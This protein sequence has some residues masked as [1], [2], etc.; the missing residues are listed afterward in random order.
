MGSIIDG[1]RAAFGITNPEQINPQ[2]TANWNAPSRSMT[3]AGH[4]WQPIG[5]RRIPPHDTY[6]NV[7]P[8]VNAIAQRFSTLTPYAINPNGERITPA[9][10]AVRAIYAPN[11]T[12]SAREFL[13]N[14]ATNILTQSHLDI[15]IWTLQGSKVL[16]G[17]RI[18][19]ENI[20]GYTFLPASSR[21]YDT[22]RT[23]YWH[24]TELTINGETDTYQFS[25]DE[26]IALSY[27]VHPN[28]PTRGI[29]PTMTIHKWANVD[30]MIA[31]YERGFF[32]NGAVPAGM[33]GIISDTP[34]D[35]QQNKNKLEDTFRGAGK[36]NG[37]VYNWIPTDPVTRKPSAT[38]KLV[39][40]PFQQSN[41]TLDLQT[42]SDVVNNRMANALAVPD[43]VRGIDNG[44]TYANAQQAE[45][46]F[47]ENTLQPLALT[48]WDKW[49]FEL[50]RI[51]GGL[52]YAIT[53][54]LDLPAQTDVENVQA[55]T[56]KTKV[57]TLIELVN[58]G[59]EVK[60]AVKALGLPDEFASLTL[61]KQEQSTPTLTL[62]NLQTPTVENKR[63][64]D[65]CHVE[66]KYNYPDYSEQKAM[67]ALLPA[68]QMFMR[69]VIRYTQRSQNGLKDDLGVIAAQWADDVQDDLDDILIAYAKR[70]GQN[71]RK[72]F[73]AWAEQHPDSEIAQQITA[74]NA[75]EWA[76][77]YDWSELPDT[78][79]EAY[80]K[81][82]NNVAL[83]SAKNVRD[84]V[85]GILKKAE[86]EQ[87]TKTE[88]KDALTAQVVDAHAELLARNEI[89]ASQRLGD[90][91]SARNMSETVGLKLDKEWKTSDDSGVCPFCKSMEGT[92]IDLDASF[93]DKG[94]SVDIDGK[95]YANDYEDMVTANGHPNCRCYILHKVHGEK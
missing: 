78:V 63:E 68:T 70:T 28:D 14:I 69:R 79:S 91:Y 73:K 20:A 58:A 74:M 18:T 12:F 27:S 87:W 11:D 72:V 95:T 75:G 85:I 57:D 60:A 36:N 88:I 67:G 3:D 24:E 55:T 53:F 45:R 64:S 65:H 31:D 38:G 29:S 21:Q 92:R 43:I 8:Y 51:T 15:L 81:H 33:L 86:T 62:P 50:D 54:N 16:P 44:Q 66:N 5:N 32:G 61:T 93:L 76:A 1:F 40:V 48:V 49:Q 37:V 30:D 6:D 90:L 47:I 22:N 2:P 77:L 25:R 7:F 39:W 41:N 42:V 46:A 94:S 83:S 84:E 17:G 4:L 35:F 19:T 23:D 71:V 80:S 13:R 52:G 9:P 59:A 89:L 10:A 34:E 26:T 56:Q 82:L